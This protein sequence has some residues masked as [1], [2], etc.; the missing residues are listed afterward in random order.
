ME[1]LVES[2]KGSN[3]VN[4]CHKY[5]L[6]ICPSGTQV[7]MDT[8][9]PHM[10]REIGAIGWFN[11]EQALAKIRSRDTEKRATLHRASQALDHFIPLQN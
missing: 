11:L 4:Y 7:A 1:P 3:G 10:S 5:F 2:F 8:K 9:N 6:A